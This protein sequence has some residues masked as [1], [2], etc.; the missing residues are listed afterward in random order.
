VKTRNEKVTLRGLVVAVLAVGL[1]VGYS[2]VDIQ[3][4][5]GLAMDFGFFSPYQEQADV[6]DT[7]VDDKKAETDSEDPLEKKLSSMTFIAGDRAFIKIYDALD[8][9][10]R[11]FWN[12]ICILKTKGIYDVDVFVNSYGG[13]AFVGFALCGLIEQA[14]K[15][16]FRF[17]AIG[18]GII[19]SAAVPVFL[20]FDN[21]I[22]VSN[23]MFMI[24][25]ASSAMEG[26]SSQFRSQSEL[27]ELLRDQYFK[28]LMDKT[29]LKDREQW[30]KWERKTEWI[31][32]ERAI[33]IGIVPME[34]VE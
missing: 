6:P 17:R 26:T 5:S 19:A 14:Q 20:S 15:E 34:G 7:I 10:D 24:H 8:Y 22:A 1:Y 27:F 30:E 33:E 16:G 29:N 13:S 3:A 18:N 11:D 4:N 25:E 21:R 12:D 31:T 28:I 2:L 9:E 32:L 23:T